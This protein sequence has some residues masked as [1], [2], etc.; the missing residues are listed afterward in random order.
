MCCPPEPKPLRRHKTI[1]TPKARDYH[2]SA[3]DE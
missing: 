2:I 1:R 3:E